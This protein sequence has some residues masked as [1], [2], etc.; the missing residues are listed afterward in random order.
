MA[1]WRLFWWKPLPDEPRSLDP[2]PP[3]RKAP[4][5]GRQNF[6]DALGPWLLHSMG[7]RF[8][9]TELGRANLV[10]IGSVLDLVAICQPQALTVVGTGFIRA[11]D[12]PP[13]W[14]KQTTFLAV[15]GHLTRTCA[16]LPR[17]VPVGDLGLLTP[18]PAGAVTK[19]GTV[20]I[21]PH[22]VD[23]DRRIL[24]P[25]VDQFIAEGREVRLIDVWNDPISVTAD[26]AACEAV[27][28]SSLHGCVVADALGVPN[29]WW[30]FT[31]RVAGSG[32]KF[33]DYY[34]A[35]WKNPPPTLKAQSAK[36][37]LRAFEAWERPG[38]AAVQQRLRAIVESL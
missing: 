19:P 5:A 38:L 21:I 1:A 27:V 12:R 35:F 3:L 33:W 36:E 18:A 14:P 8:S 23:Q 15:R 28:S 22:Y 4:A 32:F 9:R 11:Y 34:T 7:V 16:G 20:G 30:P 6:G 17:E 2:M 29:A 13:S 10:S 37:C 31:K 26:I 25:V 24:E